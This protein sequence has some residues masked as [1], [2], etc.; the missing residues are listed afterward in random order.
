MVSEVEKFKA[1]DDANRN[2][3]ESKNGLETYCY[4]LKSLIYSDQ[5]KDKIP[6]EDKDA[7]EKAIKDAISWMDAN[8]T[9]KKKEYEENQKVLE[10]V[11]MPIIQK[12]AGGE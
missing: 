7:L 2:R 11:A 12:M 6:A 10:G 5:V 1:E 4:S 9:S 3:I 8:H